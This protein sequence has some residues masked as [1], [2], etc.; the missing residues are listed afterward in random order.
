MKD[1]KDIF[2]L[3]LY[4]GS[5]VAVIKNLKTQKEIVFTKIFSSLDFI[6]HTS[7]ETF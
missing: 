6:N 5:D 2:I 4:T 7:A 3:F 1:H